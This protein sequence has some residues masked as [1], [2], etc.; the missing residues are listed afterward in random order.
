MSGLLQ[1]CIDS[2]CRQTTDDYEI[3]IIDDGSTDDTPEII[4]RNAA[5]LGDKLRTARQEN[6]GQGAARN[7]GLSMAN[8]DYVC[9]IDA[10]DM[11]A[12]RA[13]ETLLERALSDGSDI[14]HCD[15]TYYYPDTGKQRGSSPDRIFAESLL[16]G[17]ECERLLGM[18]YYYSVNNL[19]RAAF[20]AEHGIRYGDERVYEDW[21]FI[22]RCAN[23]AERVSLVDEPLYIIRVNRSSVTHSG[24]GSD[25]H[26]Q[27]FLAAIH[28]TAGAVKPRNRYTGYF[29]AKQFND[30]MAAYYWKRVPRRL[31]AAFLRDFLAVMATVD[32]ELPPKGGDAVLRFLVK[33]RVPERKRYTLYFCAM[34]FVSARTVLAKYMKG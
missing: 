12:G 30:K 16:V 6:R 22:A 24:Y 9:F 32:I 7:A 25:V 4:R 14:V 13:L 31:R 20:L 8:G 11:L 27:S 5:R 21:V 10:D 3:I 23:A 33:F 29:L 18:K 19:Y 1:D 26:Y 34:L 15:Y 2:V 17:A 28:G